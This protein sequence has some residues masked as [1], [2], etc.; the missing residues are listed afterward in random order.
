M[1]RSPAR[2]SN[3]VNRWYRCELKIR[4]SS[5]CLTQD[6]LFFM[7]DN[8]AALSPSE[9]FVPAKQY[10][11]T[12]HSSSLDFKKTERDALLVSLALEK[13]AS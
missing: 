5:V 1:L 4:S 10:G 9:V 12:I 2:T 7:E 11:S 6:E 3:N 8:Y 13:R